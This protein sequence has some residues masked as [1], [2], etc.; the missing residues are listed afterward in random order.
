M[1]EDDECMAPDAIY[2]RAQGYKVHLG[3]YGWF[4][5]KPNEWCDANG[6]NKRGVSLGDTRGRQ[7]FRSL[8]SAWQWA[9]EFHRRKEQRGAKRTGGP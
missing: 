2:A 5:V 1:Q 8:A 3:R 9:A 4:V 7:S 6:C